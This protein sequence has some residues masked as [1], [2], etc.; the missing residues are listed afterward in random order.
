MAT[1]NGLSC[2][3]TLEEAVHQSLCE[4]FERHAFKEIIHKSLTPPKIPISYIKDK[5]PEL[6]S[7]IEDINSKGYEVFFCDSSLGIDLPVVCCCLINKNS[8]SYKINFASHFSFKIAIE[9]CLTEVF[10]SFVSVEDANTKFETFS[11]NSTSRFNT[12]YNYYLRYTAGQ[13]SVPYEFFL[14]KPSWNFKDWVNIELT[15]KQC[16]I[17]CISLLKKNNYNAYIR[18]LKYEDFYIVRI[19]IPEMSPL[20][21]VES[22]GLTTKYSIDKKYNLEG[23]NYDNI[24]VNDSIDYI[25]VLTKMHNSTK[26]LIVPINLLTF[27]CY[28]DNKEYDKAMEEL[29]KCFDRCVFAR[30]VHQFLSLQKRGYEIIDIQTILITFYDKNILNKVLSMLEGNVLENILKSQKEIDNISFEGYI[31]IEKFSKEFINIC[32]DYSIKHPYNQISLRD[33]LN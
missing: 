29:L 21:F 31:E 30:I 11:D 27:A 1:S 22:K 3:N 7:I 32:I 5:C 2:G 25:N 23:H 20:K 18:Y 13:G 26:R 19:Y 24:I 10:Q 8:Q 9:R 28:Y 17:N 12:S 33:I 4:I 14:N 6:M 15:N 16:V